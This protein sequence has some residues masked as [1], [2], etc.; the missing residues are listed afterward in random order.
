RS[1]GGSSKTRILPLRNSA[2][3]GDSA[4]AAARRDASPSARHE[5][6]PS[7]QSG[8]GDEEKAGGTP[9]EYRRPSARDQKVTALARGEGKAAVDSKLRQRR[10]DPHDQ[11]LRPHRAV[12]RPDELRIGGHPEDA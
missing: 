12:L 6:V 8:D 4:N 7:G 11:R 5:A 3:G 10:Q 2:S 9:G 1:S